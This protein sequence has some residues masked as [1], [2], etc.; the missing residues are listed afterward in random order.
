MTRSLAI[1]TALIAALALGAFGCKEEGPAEKAGRKLD[2][3]V[4]DAVEKLRHGDEGA[5][6]KAGRKIDEA[7]EDVGDEIEELREDAA[8]AIEGD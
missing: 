1:R 8:D 3:A 7:V 5:I 2:E 4:D 6:E